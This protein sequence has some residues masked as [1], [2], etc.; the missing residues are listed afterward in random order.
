MRESISIRYELGD[1]KGLAF[2]FGALAMSMHA[3]DCSIL[4]AQLASAS[5][6]IRRE[7]GV[8]IVPATREENENFNTQLRLSLG[9][10]AFDTAWL[11]GQTMPLE[12]V[13]ALAYK[14]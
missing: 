14:E 13:V 11:Q 2:S 5:A 10:T 8:V 3:L 4:A 6:R 9:G 7:L 1:L 12:Q